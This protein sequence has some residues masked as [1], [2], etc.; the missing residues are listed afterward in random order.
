MQPVDFP[1]QNVVYGM[2]QHEYIALPAFDNGQ[3]VIS[4]W[5]LSVLERLRVLL[6]G[7]VWVRQLTQGAPLQP[8][9]LETTYPFQETTE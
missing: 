6:R 1:E 5:K 3:Q 4:C 7:V 8:Q 9:V 2:N